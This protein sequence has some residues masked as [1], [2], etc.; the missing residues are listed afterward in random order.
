MSGQMMTAAAFLDKNPQ[1]GEAE[2]I[3][4]MSENYCRCGCYV[5]I[6][7]AVA[8]AAELNGEVA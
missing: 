3:E 2:I 7:E 6:R 1:P 8:Y 4:A 5:R